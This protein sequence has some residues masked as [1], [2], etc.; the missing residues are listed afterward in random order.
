MRP[1]MDICTLPSR[2]TPQAWFLVPPRSSADSYIT[3]EY[4]FSVYLNFLGGRGHRNGSKF[5]KPLSARRWEKNSDFSGLEK[6]KLIS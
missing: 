3:I 6:L 5:L 4:S 1:L 2:E